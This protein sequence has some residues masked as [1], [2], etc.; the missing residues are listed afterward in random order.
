MSCRSTEPCRK[1]PG[2]REELG[3]RA[4]AAAA[5]QQ[6]KAELLPG[7]KDQDG[8]AHDLFILGEVGELLVLNWWGTGPNIHPHHPSEGDAI[9]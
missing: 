1:A 7:L 5:S 8:K 4:Q 3:S 9:I 6:K 2:P